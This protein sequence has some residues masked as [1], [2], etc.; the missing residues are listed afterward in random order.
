MSDQRIELQI[1]LD[2]GQLKVATK[3]SEQALQ[4]LGS[5]IKKAEQDSKSGMAGIAGG[6]QNL[7]NIVKGFIGLQVVQFFYNI[8]KSAL[9]GAADLEK[10]KI[11]FET[12]L[13]S[14]SRATTMMN[15]IQKMAAATPFETPGLVNAA[16]QLIAFGVAQKDVISTMT[17]LGD[18]SMGNQEIFD[19]LSLAYGKTAAK[20]RASMEEINMFIEAGVPLTA[21]LAKNMG[22]TTSELSKMIEQGK[23]GFSKVDQALTS[24]TT[25]TGQFAGMMEKQSKSLGGLF[26]TL[27]DNIKI[28]L[29]GAAGEATGPIK[30]LMSEFIDG[31]DSAGLFGDALK[32]IGFLLGAI[33]NEVLRFIN[34]IQL[35]KA[36]I[37]ELYYT[38]K[39][40]ASTDPV[41]RKRYEEEARS[42]RQSGYSASN[43]LQARDDYYTNFF[44]NFGKNENTASS[45]D[46]KAGGKPGDSASDAAKKA[47]SE[48]KK[49]VQ[50]YAQYSQLIISSAQNM[51]S[52]LTN[53]YQQQAE[54]E[55]QRYDNLQTMGDAFLEY[56]LN[57]QLAAAGFK[58]QTDS[59]KYKKEISDLQKQY[60]KTTNIQKKKE[61]KEQIELKKDLKKKA[62]IEEDAAKR[63]QTFDLMMQLIKHQMMVSQ[64][65]SNQQL[66]IANATISMLGG[67]ASAFSS[68][69]IAIPNPIA[70][71]VVGGIMSALVLG[72]GGAQIGLIAQQS[73]PAFETGG[74]FAG[75][76]LG[77]AIVAEK[78]KAEAV[79]PF[80]N[81]QYMARFRDALGMNSEPR[82]VVFQ[83]QGNVYDERGFMKVLKNVT[84]TYKW[85]FN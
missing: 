40:L 23:V 56:Q 2:N 39:A 81:E 61:L 4:G 34:H 65:R 69:F 63:K 20:G 38:G 42:A 78:N 33:V 7:T 13:G 76:P 82:T 16:K 47:A 64:F 54:M 1:W 12:M 21:Q 71:A 5:G 19:R 18:A 24:L 30:A 55:Q 36:K 26:S 77:T 80:E 9:K 8:G 52:S 6:L 70:A 37:T 48:A 41:D 67:A 66:Q 10:N 72:M 60:T 68:A 51:L 27:A 22:V 57:Q 79:I 84:Q 3:E 28:G 85:K 46:Y 43:K 58:E 14:A 74:F 32:V 53:I 31:V 44:K 29:T 83:I 35:L 75:S 50:E 49:A 45:G 62:E 11:A 59:E 15:D 17:R 25:G 73:P